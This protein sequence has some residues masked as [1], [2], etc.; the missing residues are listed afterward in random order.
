MED[1]GDRLKKTLKD[2]GM[3]QKILALEC[4]IDECAVSHYVHSTREPGF[5]CLI[6]MCQVLNVS[7]DY[8]LTGNDRFKDV[9]ADA[10]T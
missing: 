7:I 2:R 4:G 9:N 6:K 1:W 8:L 3:T 5:Y 10:L